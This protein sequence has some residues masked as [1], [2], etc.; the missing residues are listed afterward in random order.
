VG[1]LLGILGRIS[2]PLQQSQR[3]RRGISF[4]GIRLETDT[5]S[6]ETDELRRRPPNTIQVL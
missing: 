2:V 5:Q 4:T 1:R 6:S 3:T